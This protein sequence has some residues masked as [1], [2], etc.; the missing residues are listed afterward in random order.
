LSIE[1]TKRVKMRRGNSSVASAGNPAHLKAWSG[2]KCPPCL[3]LQAP[4]RQTPTRENAE[5]RG[6]G[7]AAGEEGRR[8]EII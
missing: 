2:S 6:A 3:G 8:D 5:T 4:P 7:E 1:G